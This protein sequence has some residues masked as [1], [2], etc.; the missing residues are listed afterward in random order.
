[1]APFNDVTTSFN[2]GRLLS[3]VDRDPKRIGL[4]VVVVPIQKNVSIGT[5]PLESG[6]IVF[7]EFAKRVASGRASRRFSVRGCVV[8][9]TPLISPHQN[10][11][12]S[13]K[14]RCFPGPILTRQERCG[15]THIQ[16]FQIQE[17]PLCKN[18][19]L[20]EMRW[21]WVIRRCHQTPPQGQWSGV[22][23]LR[24]LSLYR[25]CS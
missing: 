20:K 22:T 3:S 13:I 8:A 5:F 15:Y 2:A 19:I 24:V 7:L 16:G 10:K 23:H 18:K 21:H 6:D 17:I 1:M 14:Y 25:S 9:N 12:D 11:L 4:L